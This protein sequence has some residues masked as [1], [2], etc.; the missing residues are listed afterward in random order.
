M[1]QRL[2]IIRGN[3]GSGKSTVAKKLQLKLGD[4]TML[5][6]QD[7]V[8]RELLRSH[9]TE[10]NDSIQ[11]IYDIAMY[12]SNHGYDVIVE[13]IFRKKKYGEMLSKLLNEFNGDAFIYYFDVS[14][15]ETL[16]RHSF[17][18]HRDEYGEAEMRDWW[19]DEDYM[20]VHGEKFITDAMS[21]DEAVEMIY[22]EVSAIA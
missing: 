19:Q 2:I 22:A 17:K 7:V 8:R 4:K 12:G 15:N 3:S 16:R 13:G 6:P 18:P 10:G 1:S 20:N 9:D 14:F 21:E 11:L 5:V